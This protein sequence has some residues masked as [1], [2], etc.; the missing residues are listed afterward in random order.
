MCSSLPS[1]GEMPKL[2]R[3][4]VW[5]S[6]GHM[7]KIPHILNR[8]SKYALSLKNMDPS[9]IYYSFNRFKFLSIS[10]H[11]SNWVFSE[12]TI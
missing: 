7:A 9:F 11:N 3:F 4:S 8:V 10:K 2:N 6:G 1:R 12:G 5:H